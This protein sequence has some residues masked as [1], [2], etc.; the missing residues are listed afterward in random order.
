[1]HRR[2]GAG[3]ACTDSHA[4]NNWNH[5]QFIRGH[6]VHILIA[7]CYKLIVASLERSSFLSLQL[8]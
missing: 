5:P 6:V 7:F 2:H 4:I 1:M 8:A 3:A